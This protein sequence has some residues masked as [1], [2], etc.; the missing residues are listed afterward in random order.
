MPRAVALF[1]GG[2]DSML[3]V[4]IMQQQGFDVEA[5]NLRTLYSCCQTGAA[6]IA[7]AMGVRL[8]VLS[9]GDDYVDVIRN[10]KYG[11]GRAVNPCIDCRIYMC[12]MARRFMEKVGAC[13][14]VTGEVAGQRPMSQK[15]HQLAIIARRSGLEGRL[16]R[17]LSAR[18][19]PPTAAELEGL[20]DRQGLYAFS[21]RARRPLMALAQ[22]LKIP[23]TG[24]GRWPSPS[25]GCALTEPTFAPRV[26]DLL[27]CHPD[28]GRWDFEVLNHGRHFRFDSQTRVVVGRN[29]TENAALRLLALRKDAPEVA[30]LTPENFRGPDALVVGSA[31]PPVVEF[32][33]TLMLRYAQ[34]EHSAGA[35]VCVTGPG[36][37]SAMPIRADAAALSAASL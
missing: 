37:R 32:A 7:A 1:S 8:T 16:L 21:G 23:E 31:S 20:V 22:Q 2:L 18:L 10:P 9:V 28:A 33:G 27:R 6:Q 13:V 35:K 3:S 24:A 34:A 26:R 15:K 30:L 25:T 29:A 12:R 19:L 17:P 14:V 4:R 5:L 11:Y 36:G